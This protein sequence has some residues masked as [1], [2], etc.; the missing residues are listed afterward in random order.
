MTDMILT[1]RNKEIEMKRM[2]LL[3]MH[4]V[5]VVLLAVLL[6]NYRVASRAEVTIADL[7]VANMGAWERAYFIEHATPP[8][9][10]GSG[11]N[12]S[13]ALVAAINATNAAGNDNGVREMLM[14]G[15]E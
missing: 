15:L 7:D 9:L 5:V 13:I 14:L 12:D 6:S 1:L 8:Q 10:V 3:L 4:V 2:R 11:V